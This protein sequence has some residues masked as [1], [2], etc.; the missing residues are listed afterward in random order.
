M[1]FLYLQILFFSLLCLPFF[2]SSK[3]VNQARIGFEVPKKEWNFLPENDCDSV[4]VIPFSRAGNLILLPATID[5]VKGNFILDTGAPGLVLNFTYFRNYPI[6]TH[7][8]EKAAGLESMNLDRQ[9]TLIGQLQLDCFTFRNVD[10]DLVNLG[11]LENAKSVK[12]LGLLGVNLFK[13]FEMIIDYENNL[14][15]L[16]HIPKKKSKKGYS[17]LLLESSGFQTLNFDLIDNKI[18]TRMWVAGKKLRFILDSGAESN[19]LDSRLPNVIFENVQVSRRVKLLGTGTGGVDALAGNLDSLK[20]GDMIFDGLP[21]LVT[22][23]EKSCLSYVNC[24]DGI[25]GFD[26]LS[27]HKIGFNFVDRKIYIWK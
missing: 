26:F 8:D 20:V 24:T 2:N 10:A 13:R 23:L 17:S 3:W 27:L 25:L 4:V 15:Y 22:N 14:L 12:I 9:T 19:L 18:I 7:S 16:Q 6:S 1:R 11:H 5:S 21:V